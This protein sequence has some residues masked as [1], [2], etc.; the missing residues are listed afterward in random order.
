MSKVIFLDIDG[1]LNSENH[2]KEMY[3]LKESNPKKYFD[4]WDLPYEGTLK[5]L[6]RI[7]QSTG[8]IIVLSSTWRF[9]RIP[10][11][12]KIFE[13]YGFQI[14]DKT[15]D[16]VSLE[17][18]AKLGFDPNN[19]YSI[20]KNSKGEKYT[21]DRGAEIAK[22][23]STHQDI[24]SFVILDDD[25]ADIDQYFEANHV[26]TDF[27]DWGLTEAKADIAIKILNKS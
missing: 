22:W 4:T 16:G 21:T 7:I 24:E 26:W 11:L 1:V 8:A 17:E 2:A 23:L 13:R 25:W 9:R 20:Y 6:Q 3:A 5:P 14:F 18:V 27:Y 19:C 15:C 12:N 10:K